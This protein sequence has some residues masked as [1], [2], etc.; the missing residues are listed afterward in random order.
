MMTAKLMV[1]G[2]CNFAKGVTSYPAKAH[3]MRTDRDN[4]RSSDFSAGVLFFCTG[5][6]SRKPTEKWS[7]YMKISEGSL[8][9]LK[10]LLL[11]ATAPF[12]TKR[13]SVESKK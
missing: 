1:R 12:K 3:G 13:A 10:K 6:V 4:D 5:L 8:S 9:D 2:G 7:T 11:R